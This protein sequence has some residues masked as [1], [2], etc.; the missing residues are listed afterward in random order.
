MI[1]GYVPDF[2]E[3]M[4]LSEINYARL[5]RLLPSGVAQPGEPIQ[6]QIKQ[7]EYRLIIEE[8]TKYTTRVNIS[9][10]EQIAD[11]LSLPSMSVRLYHDA[12]VAEVCA[13]KQISHFKARYDYPN[14]KLNQRD[15]KHQINQFLA[16]WLSYCLG[17]GMLAEAL[18]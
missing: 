11:Y 2:P 12:R 1:K 4:R 13:T 17:Y 15:E 8:S 6:Y 7:I 5:I 10:M 3:M 9:Q 16:E 14:K 18:Y